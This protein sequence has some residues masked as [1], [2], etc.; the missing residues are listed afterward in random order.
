MA[1]Y[2]GTNMA[3]LTCEHNSFQVPLYNEKFNNTINVTIV[4]HFNGL[5]T[6]EKVYYYP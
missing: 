6:K 1:D 4:G 3:N 5:Q 2:T